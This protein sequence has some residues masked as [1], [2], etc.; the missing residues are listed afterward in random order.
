[1]LVLMTCAVF[2]TGIV[3]WLSPGPGGCTGAGT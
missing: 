2:M 1:M 3:M